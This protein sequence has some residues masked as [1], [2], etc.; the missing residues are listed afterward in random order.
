M[1]HQLRWDVATVPVV[2]QRRWTE[3]RAD[4]RHDG[5]LSFAE[6]PRHLRR[7]RVHRNLPSVVERHRRLEHMGSQICA[8]HG[9][10]AASALVPTVTYGVVGHERVVPVVA[11]VEEDADERFVVGWI[12]ERGCALSGQ[13]VQADRRG[14]SEQS[15]LTDE[16]QELPSGIS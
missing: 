7:E 2:G 9:D 14:R 5:H 10:C 11:A 12:G 13:E 1:R 8:W 3:E 15:S 16:A 4:V 6:E